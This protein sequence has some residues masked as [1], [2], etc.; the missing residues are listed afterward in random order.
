MRH[1]DARL[2]CV[3]PDVLESGKGATVT[4]TAAVKDYLDAHAEQFD[5]EL[6]EFLRIPSVS[7]DPKHAADTRKTAEW[8]ADRARKAGRAR[9]DSL[10]ET[11]LHPVVYGRWETSSEKP[12]LL[13]YGH[14]DV[15]PVDPIEL[16]ESDPFEPTERDGKI[17]ARGSSDMKMNLLGILQGIEALAC[18]QG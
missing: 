5:A 1:H 17:Y 18:G 13:I 4:T 14:Y 9:R 15:Q 8:V 16:W 10:I 6:F 2:N 12:T 7:T 3:D 11:P